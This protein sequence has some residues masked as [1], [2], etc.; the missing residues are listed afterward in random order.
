[1]IKISI[2]D[3]NLELCEYLKELLLQMYV[4]GVLVTVY[5]NIPEML[6]DYERGREKNVAD[7]LII[8][9]EVDAVNGID[10]A[11]QLQ[12]RFG[13]LQ[14]IFITGNPDN[15]TDIFRAD[16]SNLL[17]KPIDHDRLKDAIDKAI[18]RLKEE[19]ISCL[20]ISFKGNELRL[21]AREIL[22]LESE[23]RMVIVHGRYDNWT[24]YRKLDDVQQELPDYFLRCHQ[25]YLVNMNEIRSL[26]PLCIELYRGDEIPVSR[27]K[28]RDTKE[29]FMS[30]IGNAKDMGIKAVER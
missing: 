7:I 29:R 5:K 6:A 4:E 21:P 12:N 18:S 14:V 16:P 10:V 8:D 22:Y 9:I 2:C 24:I 15:S 19:I 20:E 27:P 17:L 30:Y 26:K 1:M 11:V 3:D 13:G 28:Y 25:S 23:K